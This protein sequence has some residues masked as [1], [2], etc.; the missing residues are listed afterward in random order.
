[1]KTIWLPLILLCSG[2][3]AMAADPWGWLDDVDEQFWTDVRIEG[4]GRTI[5]YSIPDRSGAGSERPRIW[6]P[7]EDG[8]GGQEIAVPLEA[9]TEPSL[10]LGQYLWDRW[11]GGFFK[12]SGHD[13]SLNVRVKRVEDGIALLD[14]SLEERLRRPVEFR[15][16]IYSKPNWESQ[17][18][19]EYFFERF[20][21][22]SFESTDGHVWVVQN[23]PVVTHDH[24]YYTIPISDHH[25]LEFSFFVREK[26]YD[27][28]D[29][30]EWN[31]RRWALAE[32][33][34]NTV[35]IMPSPFP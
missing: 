19:G 28:K 24:V 5:T 6:P 4:Y 23:N 1:M 13:F 3:A 22:K 30:P 14:L 17:K 7:L 11:W 33:I 34:M 31:A 15:Q 32:Q 2:C 12:G 29:D 21:V 10:T 8:N 16:A 18:R 9:F 27:W 35:R 26:R 20:W 25:I